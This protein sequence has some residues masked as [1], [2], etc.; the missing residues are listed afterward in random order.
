MLGPLTGTYPK[1]AVVRL[2]LGE[3]LLWT[4]QVKKGEQQLRAAVAVQ[5]GSVY[6]ASAEKILEALRKDGTK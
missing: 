6:A 3:L 4:K 5:P 1:A 2:H